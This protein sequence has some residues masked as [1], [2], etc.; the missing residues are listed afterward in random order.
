MRNNHRKCT[1]LENNDFGGKPC[2]FFKTREQA[3]ADY[4]A[5]YRRLVEQGRFDLIQK[6]RIDTPESRR[7]RRRLN[8][9]EFDD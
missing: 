5:A 4:E 6:Y 9:D 2:P 8:N 3:D 7:N 1:V